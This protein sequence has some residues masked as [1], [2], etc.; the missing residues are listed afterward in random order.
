MS[1]LFPFP[2]LFV[3]HGHMDMETADG[4]LKLYKTVMKAIL[5]TEINMLAAKIGECCQR[6]RFN[7]APYGISA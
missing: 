5:F 2:F 6:R 7:A 1:F 4:K 3:T